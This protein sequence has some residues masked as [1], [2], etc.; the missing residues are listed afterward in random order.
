MDVGGTLWPDGAR[1]DEF[2]GVESRYLGPPAFVA[3]GARRL[4]ALGVPAEEATALANA[5]ADDAVEEEARLRQDTLDRI[6][7]VLRAKNMDLDPVATL[8]AMCVPARDVL[9]PFPGTISMLRE[10]KRVGKTMALVSN[11][12]WRSG[13]RYRED[14]AEWEA[15][16]CFDAYVTSLDVGFRKP[17]L[18]MFKRVLELLGV[19]ATE[20]V[21]IGDSPSKD[22]VPAKA[23]DMKTVLVA[24]QTPPPDDSAGA[25]HVVTSVAAL[26]EVLLGQDC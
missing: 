1:N 12:R 21:M 8:E 20:S 24:F 22:V 25:D 11:S 5:L 7:R 10:L 3:G 4:R 14:F 13:A 16:R 23:L 19:E 26:R 6:R 9:D 15:D 2:V 17:H 18:A